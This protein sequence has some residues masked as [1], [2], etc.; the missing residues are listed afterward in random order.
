MPSF[1]VKRATF[2][3]VDLQSSNGTWVNG[4]RVGPSHAPTGDRVQIGRT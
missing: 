3:V 1:T 4:K 2:E